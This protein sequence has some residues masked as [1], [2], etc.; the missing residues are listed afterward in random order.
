MRSCIY[1]EA[2]CYFYMWAIRSKQNCKGNALTIHKTRNEARQR[3]ERLRYLGFHTDE[4]RIVK[5]SCE[6]Y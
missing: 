1:Y 5:I 6:E 3:M 4:F 2:R